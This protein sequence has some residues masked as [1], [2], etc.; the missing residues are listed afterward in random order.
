MKKKII[1]FDFDKTLTYKDTLIGYY[2]FVS[3]KNYLFIFKMFIYLFYMVLAKIKFVSNDKLKMKGVNLFLKGQNIMKLKQKSIEYSEKIILNKLYFNYDFKNLNE[4]II[5]V[6]ASF[7]DYI[8]SLFPENVNVIGSKLKIKD[9][10]VIHLDFNCYSERKVEILMK[11]GILEIDILYTDSIS[12]LP[13]ANISK[14]IIL[15]KKDIT[16]IFF[17]IEKFKLHLKK[18]KF[19]YTKYLKS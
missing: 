14:K 6:S 10:K 19:S 4:R 3:N 9:N 7:Q 11:K 12:D 17:S 18:S 13:L 5:I 15:V 8:Y 16:K 1:V 2:I